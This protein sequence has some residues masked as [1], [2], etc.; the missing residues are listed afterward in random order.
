MPTVGEILA[1]MLNSE[2]GAEKVATVNTD[3]KTDKTEAEKIAE[4]L[5]LTPEEIEA[6]SQ[7]LEEA[8]KTAEAE[9]RAEEAVYLGRFMAQGFVNEL[10]KL[11]EGVGGS[12]P[13]N[14]AAQ[15]A[16]TPQDGSV[17]NRVAE[18][19]AN[20][21]GQKQTPKKE[22]LK[23]VLQAARANFMASNQNSQMA[24][25]TPALMTESK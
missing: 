11:G 22:E 17:A 10:Q 16:S 21:H 4:S 15:G 1:Q 12:E 9:K 25:P 8:E 18:A 13:N 24:V 20:A 5:N 14:I 2:D 6:A 3:G 19:I 23:A 7:E